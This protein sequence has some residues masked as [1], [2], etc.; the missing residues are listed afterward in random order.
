MAKK[1]NQ[2]SQPAETVIVDQETI[3]V[4]LVKKN[5]FAYRVLTEDGKDLKCRCGRPVEAVLHNVSVTNPKLGP[6]ERV[7]ITKR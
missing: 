5:Q 2:G 1:D 7:I 3:K 6:C 4:T